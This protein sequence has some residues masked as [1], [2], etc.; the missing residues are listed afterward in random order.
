MNKT[1]KPPT[2]PI[3]ELGPSPKKPAF[4]LW[5][6]QGETFEIPSKFKIVKLIG[7]GAYGV[8]VQA[9]DLTEPEERKLTAIKKIKRIF[10]H[11]I[12]AKRTLRELKI[13]RLLE[14]ENVLQIRHV[15]EPDPVS[16]FQDIY[17]VLDLMETDLY[18]IIRSKQ[19]LSEKHLIYFLHQILKGLQ[20]MHAVGILHRDLKPN[21]L[22][23]NSD[24]D[25]KICD[26]GLSRAIPNSTEQNDKTFNMTDYVVTRNYRA[27]EVIFSQKQYGAEV[28][29]WSVGCIFAELI[30]GKMLFP[31]E[32]EKELLV[33]IIELCGSF[34]QH[35]LDQCEDEL[36][37]EFLKTL[38]PR[39]SQDF[40]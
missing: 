15:I 29:M 12:Y 7:N 21:N 2:I 20:H 8:V 11:A 28:D 3:K 18:Q 24:C 13:M 22:L 40:P 30:R 39:Q 23:M 33:M 26:F 27:P 14:H 6:V 25:L 10:Q 32:N 17:L 36:L 16:E 34:P 5:D 19:P 31:A 1:E 4:K 9:E 38:E 35:V 37:Y